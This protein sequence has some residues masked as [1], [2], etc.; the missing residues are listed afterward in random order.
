MTHVVRLGILS[1]RPRVSLHILE[2]VLAIAI[3]FAPNRA[4]S[5]LIAVIHFSL[6]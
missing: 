3:T 1:Q 2:G 5:Q 6:P 4:K